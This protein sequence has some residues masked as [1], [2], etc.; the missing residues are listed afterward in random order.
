MSVGNMSAGDAPTSAVI[1]PRLDVENR[2]V[3]YTPLGESARVK[4]SLALVKAHLM[5]PTKL[6]IKPTDSDAMKF[7]MLCKARELN[8]WVGDAFC[9]GYDSEDGATFNLITSVQALFKRADLS[10]NFNG[11]ESGVIVRTTDGKVEERPGEWFDDG[12]KLLGGWARVFRK[13]R[14]KPIYEAIKLATFNKKRG[15]WNSQPENQIAKCAEAGAL[16]KAFPNQCSGL[17]LREELDHHNEA[18]SLPRVQQE[19]NALVGDLEDRRKGIPQTVD[20]P[21]FTPVAKAETVAKSKPESK[22]E[23]KAE[24]RAEEPQ[25]EAVH[26]S[27]TQSRQIAA[28]SASEDDIVTDFRRQIDALKA[29]EDGEVLLMAIRRS[30]ALEE[31]IK[32]TLS[33][34]VNAK[35]ATLRDQQA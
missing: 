16:R 28:T 32:R 26:P 13:D 14:D 12:E 21:A 19:M 8:P 9:V 35:L 33:R 4:L 23:H 30:G 6:G 25:A 10:P 18:G 11:I 24:S 3:E 27:A 2:E 7:M 22:P 29:E 31:D 15:L 20:A 34:S 1:V 5:P 17:Y